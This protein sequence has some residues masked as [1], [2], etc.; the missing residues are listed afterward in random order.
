MDGEQVLE[1]AL[2][3][4][5]CHLANHRF[6]HGHCR[7]ADIGELAVLLLSSLLGHGLLQFLVIRI[8]HVIK[9]DTGTFV[10]IRL[11][12]RRGWA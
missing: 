7:Q 10:P 11:A 3:C 12:R 8:A 2:V 9:I 4:G 5:F 1:G 6:I